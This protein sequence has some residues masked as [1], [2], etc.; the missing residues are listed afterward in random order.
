MWKQLISSIILAV[1][2]KKKINKRKQKIP[3]PM[4]DHYNFLTVIKLIKILPE[5][6]SF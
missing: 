4:V 5:F 1:S 3:E 6:K 2:R